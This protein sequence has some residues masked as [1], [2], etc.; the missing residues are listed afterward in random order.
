MLNLQNSFA[1]P[2]DGFYPQ[3]NHL[4][5]GSFNELWNDPIR[6]FQAWDTL[7]DFMAMGF[8]E[9]ELNLKSQRNKKW[10]IKT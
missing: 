3:L 10:E 5:C 7:C 6:S 8:K 9:P 1:A 4:K 2:H